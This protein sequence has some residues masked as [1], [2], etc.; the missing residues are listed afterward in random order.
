MILITGA[1]GFLG[2]ELTRQLAEKGLPLRATRR[3]RSLHPPQLSPYKNIEWVEADLLN[4]ASI[5]YALRD[6]TR[7]YHCAAMLSFDPRD[8]QALIRTNVTGT[9]NLVNACLAQGNIRMVHV[10]SIAAI[11]DAK[12]GKAA[13]EQDE[14]ENSP[15]IDGYGISKYESEM[16]VWRGI[17][18][19]LEAV[20]VNPSIIIGESAGAKGSGKIFET[21]RRGLRFY[22]RGGCG[23][24]DVKDVAAVMIRLMD[25]TVSAQRYIINAENWS[26]KALFTLAAKEL[27]VTPPSKEAKPWMLELAWRLSAFA[28]VFGLKAGLDKT[29]A[30]SASIPQFYE[31]RKITSETG[32]VFRPV[33]ETVAEICAALKTSG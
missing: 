20:I 3:S 13:N 12:P 8:K 19:G 14:Y 27:G 29:T 15:D 1:T 17:A 6:V 21:V 16:E 23:F 31:N 5:E 11:A 24:V 18:E 4:T 26:Y 7:V 25:S 30:R 9:G 28:R 22:T 32:F 33:Q 10:S 2:A